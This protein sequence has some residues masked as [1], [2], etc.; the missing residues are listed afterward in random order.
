MG[1]SF[2]SRRARDKAAAEAR[3]SLRGHYAGAISRALAAGIDM[4]VISLASTATLVLARFVLSIE[5]VRTFLALLFR[6]LPVTQSLFKFLAEPAVITA[7]LGLGTLLYYSLLYTLTGQTIGKYILGLRVVSIDG[8]RLPLRRSLVR[9][10]LL[11]LSI[12]PLFLGCL[13]MLGDDRRQ[14]WHDKIVRTYVLYA[15]N[16]RY[17]ESFERLLTFVRAQ[18]ERL[19]RRA[20]RKK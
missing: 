18:P 6:A 4:A 19:T 16:A 15:W 11:P 14:T 2:L 7:C 8:Q 20:R 10:L 5:T 13:W 17:D 3:L 1:Q 9:T 12:A